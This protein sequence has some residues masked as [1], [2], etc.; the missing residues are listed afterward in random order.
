MGL[1]SKC[2]GVPRTS[3]APIFGTQLTFPVLASFGLL[4]GETCLFQAQLS[5]RILQFTPMRF[6][7]EAACRRS[8][9]APKELSTL[10]SLARSWCHFWKF[11]WPSFD[12]KENNLGQQ[13]LQANLQKT[14]TRLSL[15]SILTRRGPHTIIRR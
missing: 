8:S 15:S 12:L 4:N 3:K 11:R 5:H 9:P 14:S 13:A 6:P 1:N 10:E 2:S 7:S